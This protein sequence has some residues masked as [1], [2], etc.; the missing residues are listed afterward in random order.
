MTRSAWVGMA[1]GVAI[2]AGIYWFLYGPKNAVE[3]LQA[4]L[5][6]TVDQTEFI[7]PVDAE[8]VIEHLLP[9]PGLDEKGKVEQLPELEASDEITG[10]T[11]RELFGAAPAESLLVPRDIVRRFVLTVDSLDREPLPL[12]LRPVRRVP[13]LFKV[14]RERLPVEL[15]PNAESNQPPVER[16]TID[17]KNTRRYAPLMALVDGLNVAKFAT[18]Y[19]R[20]YPLIQDSYDQLGN[21]RRRYFNDRFINVIDHLLSTPEF[22]LPIALVRPKVVYKFA[23]PELEARSSGQK[24][25]LRIGSSNARK[26]KAKLR[27]LRREIATKSAG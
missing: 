26:V 5:P 9:E 16:L 11:L 21:P 4:P 12:W 14:E 18:A 3:I 17:E 25:L 7:D 10:E 8:P 23:D 15:E 27:E 19:K 24:V 1:I 2:L 22:E 13:G 20:Y 6:E